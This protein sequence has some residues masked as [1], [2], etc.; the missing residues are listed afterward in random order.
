MSWTAIIGAW[1]RNHRSVG[2]HGLQL[3]ETR[4]AYDGRNSTQ[5]IATGRNRTS[6]AHANC[7]WMEGLSHVPAPRRVHFSNG[8]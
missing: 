1:D 5:I 3:A 4:P 7:N 2:A 6:P 8:A